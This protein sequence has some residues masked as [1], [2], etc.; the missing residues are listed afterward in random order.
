M[1]DSAWADKVEPFGPTLS[2]RLLLLAYSECL[3]Q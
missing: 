2:M 3:I 1:G